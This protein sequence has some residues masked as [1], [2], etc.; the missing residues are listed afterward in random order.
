MLLGALL[1]HSF[2]G[3][4]S[5]VDC[6]GPLLPPALRAVD[7]PRDVLLRVQIVSTGDVISAAAGAGGA[8]SDD[9]DD[10]VV[11]ASFVFATQR[12]LLALVELQPPFVRMTNASDGQQL[13]TL[14]LPRESPCLALAGVGDN[15]LWTLFRGHVL[16][17][18]TIV[19]NLLARS[20]GARG[21]VYREAQRRTTELRRGGALDPD[22]AAK[23]VREL[24]GLRLLWSW[25]ARGGDAHWML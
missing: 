24:G 18:D 7:G 19:A 16:G 21:F 8:M 14:R 3:G 17:Y 20:F 6:L 11:D 1:H 5:S 12:A 10:A 13:P 22:D 9:A 15:A 4:R 2:V 23:S 25:L